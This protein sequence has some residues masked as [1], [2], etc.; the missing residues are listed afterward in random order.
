MRFRPSLILL[1]TFLALAS[2][3]MGRSAFAEPVGTEPPPD[4][5]RAAA[6]L[7]DAALASDEAWTRLVEL[8]DGIGHRLSGSAGLERA[9][10]WAANAMERDGLENVR[11]QPVRVPH[12]IRGNESAEML[13]PERRHLHMLGL[14]QSVGTPPEGV[15]GSVVVV[16]DFQ[17]FEALSPDAVRGRIVLWNCAFESYG[18][19]VKYR[20]EGARLAS[21]KGAIASL[22]RSVGKGNP[23]VP[24]TGTLTVWEPGERAIPA[25]AVSIEDAQVIARLAA[26]GESVVVSLKMEARLAPDAESHNVIGE[27]V[28]RELPD[29]I[30]VIGA[31]LDS[32]DVGQGAQDDGG[33]CV[34]AL[35][36]ARL[37]TELGLR[38]RRTI[39]VVLWTNEENG[40][41]GAA[42]YLESVRDQVHSHVAAIESDGGVEMPW[43][44]GVSVWENETRATDERRQRRILRSL[45][46]FAALLAP[47]GAGDVRP[48]GGGADVAPLM[49][50]GVP[51]I[52]LRT[53]MTRYW[54]V[55]HTHADTVDKVDP[56]ALRHNVAA[57]AVLAYALAESPTRLDSGK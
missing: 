27:I 28:G 41:R 49:E 56:V 10:D 30:V 35:E 32:W 15:T 42:A 13:S 12:W 44:F 52:A 20:R 40:E 50:H 57:M 16:D 55:H 29:E 47:I 26:A 38:P 24:H 14:G 4:L 19:T 37:L 8:C 9:V 43:G 54:D 25:A 48:G 17:A 7:I 6:R 53:P 45:R 11:R 22:V 23:R 33:G 46:G 39:R 21:R 31:H 36:A 1:A 51:G 18:R 3:P 34:V 5:E 2:V